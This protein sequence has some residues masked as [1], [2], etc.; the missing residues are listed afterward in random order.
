[1]FEYEMRINRLTIDCEEKEAE[2]ERL[3]GELERKEKEINTYL[4]RLQKAHEKL[5]Q[6]TRWRDIESAPK[7]GTEVWGHG[8]GE[9]YVT[10]FE[11]DVWCNVCG[12]TTTHW[13]P[14]P[15]APNGDEPS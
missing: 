13:L 4:D 1:M 10:N 3:K 12:L 6:A 15:P 7:D 8:E 2:I 5:E 9:Q 11:D 14:L